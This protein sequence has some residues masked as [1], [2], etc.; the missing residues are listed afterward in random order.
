[1]RAEK[2]TLALTPALGSNCAAKQQLAYAVRSIRIIS[3]SSMLAHSLSS[4]EAA[5]CDRHFRREYYRCDPCPQRA[6]G[7]VN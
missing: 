1:M 5:N 6:A 4:R 3:E 7:Q 2:L